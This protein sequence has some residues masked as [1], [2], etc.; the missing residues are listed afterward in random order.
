LLTPTPNTISDFYLWN[1][2][3]Y[4]CSHISIFPDW[5][6][7]MDLQLWSHSGGFRCTLCAAILQCPLV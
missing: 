6:I 4:S 3:F 2:R 1:K 7:R 5:T